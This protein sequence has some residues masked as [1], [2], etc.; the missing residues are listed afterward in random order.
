MRYLPVRDTDF[1]I[2]VIAEEWGLFGIV[3]I[4]TMFF[5][6]FYWVIIYAGSISNRFSSLSLIG[7]ASIIF[8]HLI[9]NMGMTVGLF[10]V[11]GLPAPFISYGGSFLLTCMLIQALTNNII[12]YYI[13]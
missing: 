9:V 2:S 7:F 1:I 6:M 11:T 5:I 4:L 10:P 12:N 13:K 3:L 8:F